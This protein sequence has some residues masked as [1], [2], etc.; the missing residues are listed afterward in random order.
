MA[1]G[2]EDFFPEDGVTPG[3]DEWL[4]GGNDVAGEKEL[5]RDAVRRVRAIGDRGKLA[6][7]GYLE[8]LEATGGEAMSNLFEKGKKVASDFDFQINVLTRSALQEIRLLI[9]E[10]AGKF[11]NEIPEKAIERGAEFFSRQLFAWNVV[12]SG[13]DR[14]AQLVNKEA[15][16]VD[17]VREAADKWQDYLSGKI[18]E[19]DI[20]LLGFRHSPAIF[21]NIGAIAEY[22]E[23]AKE[24]GLTDIMIEMPESN[25]KYIDRYFATGKFFEDDDPADYKKIPRIVEVENRR[26]GRKGFEELV[27][28]MSDT[29]ASRKAINMLYPVEK[30]RQV[31]L[32]VKCFDSNRTG[33]WVTKDS[34][35]EA[36]R[37]ADEVYEQRDQ[38]MN[39]KFVGLAAGESRKVLAFLGFDHVK[40]GDPNEKTLQDFLLGESRLKSVGIICDRDYSKDKFFA[41]LESSD[42]KIVNSPFFSRLESEKIR[43]VGFDLAPGMIDK[44]KARTNEFTLQFDGYI[45]I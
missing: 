29:T 28:E 1:N 43:S 3:N 23:K 26:A 6:G 44:K 38:S 18:Q 11:K 19:N 4:E 10:K 20:V 40:H 13:E 14:A 34:I 32:A 21:E 9:W 25:Q 31:G 33:G 5:F 24:V 16:N 45:K 35:D 2:R 17:L 30:A 15:V 22:L 8:T 27:G 36:K 37:H 41:R 39:E 42:R 12:D 7:S